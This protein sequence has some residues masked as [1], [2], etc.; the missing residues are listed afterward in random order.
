MP[1]ELSAK[2]VAALPQRRSP[3]WVAPLL[4]V[5]KQHPPG[6]W[7]VL[8]V[9]PVKGRRVEMGLGPV[10]DPVL[11][12][13]A[14]KASGLSLAE[15]KAKAIE[16]RAMILRG[17]CPLSE[18]QEE[19]ERRQVVRPRPGALRSF[20]A[21]AEAYCQLHA[22][23][24]GKKH[25]QQ[26]EGSLRNYILPVLGPLP[27]ARIDVDAV[28]RVVEPIW[29]AKAQTANRVRSRIETL[30]D[31]ATA[32]KLFHGDNPARWKGGLQQALPSRDRVRRVEHRA[33]LPWA[34]IPEF[35]ARLATDPSIGALAL[36]FLILTAERTDET[37]LATIAEIDRDQRL[38]TVRAERVKTRALLRV[39]LADE[40]LR[41]LDL[42][43]QRRT[44][45]LLFGGRGHGKPIN[46]MALLAKLHQ[47][48]VT[49]T[50]HGFRS[51]FRDWCADHGV[52]REIS[53]GCLGH[54]I[55]S[56]TE[57]AY[58]RSDMLERRRVV[59][60]QWAGFVTG[61][62]EPAGSVITI[63]GERRAG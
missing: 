53:E 10:R 24:W 42:V 4:Y 43:E 48:G 39:P 56:A 20:A 6:F 45:P 1:A 29:L 17:R 28:L 50:V 22:P 31:Y 3:Y 27:I 59:M 49:A 13:E 34:E 5:N 30:I 32:R 51:S 8:Y 61:I 37:R 16:C 58:Q 52:V 62:A 14:A 54:R 23:T 7:L 55:G 46:D 19:R 9:S 25:A 33:A 36:R 38:H 40:A 12:G 21:V 44:S 18:R 15:A 60:A 26:W 41:I 2:A 11:S 57:Q 47:H 35:Y 63:G